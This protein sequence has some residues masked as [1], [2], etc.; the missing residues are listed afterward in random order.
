MSKTLN[1]LRVGAVAL[2]CASPALAQD[3]PTADTIVATVNDTK[4]TLGEMIA[5]REALPDQYKDIPSKVLF[6]SI[7][8]QLVQQ[9][10]LAQ[11]L[12][13]DLPRI[14][15]FTLENEKRAL[16][17]TKALEDF[18][19]DREITD[20]E[21]QALYESQFAQQNNG[22]EFNASHILVASE[23]EAID[24]IA[25][26]EGGADFAE[27]AKEKS[28]GPSG[29]SG[30]ELGWFGMGQMVQPFEAA[31][32]EMA[33]GDVSAPV[34]TQFGWHVI[35][36]NDSREIEA[37]SFEETRE[38]L[39]GEAQE[40][41]VRDYIAELSAEA[42]IDQSGAVDLDPE[43]LKRSDLLDDATVQD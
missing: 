8:E 13:G 3:T 33:A 11:T 26:L 4:I 29:P 23:Q 7:L 2:I 32:A 5:V 25:T 14:V 21:L 18:V 1:F 19:A 30:G 22:M 27:L 17:A 42:A 28:T 40:K 24:L 9:T 20:E 16:L 12:G 37:P 41:A 36:L 15:Q 6:E 38:Q 35:K 31:V 10:T 43:I 39:V 34:K